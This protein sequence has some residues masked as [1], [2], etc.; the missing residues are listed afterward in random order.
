MFF[1][2]VLIVVPFRDSAYKIIQ[3]FIH[4]MI[5]EDKGNVINKL[6]FIKDYTGSELTMPKKNPKPEDYEKLFSGNTGDDFKI[7]ITVTKK[8]LKVII[9]LK[10]FYILVNIFIFIHLQF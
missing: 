8:S 1:L 3:N 2:Q 4:V 7:G 6:R 10:L 9:Y 5:P